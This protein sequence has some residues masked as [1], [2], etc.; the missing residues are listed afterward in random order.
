MNTNDVSGTIKF[1]VP[2]K[3]VTNVSNQF[4]RNSENGMLYYIK[5]VINKEPEKCLAT[6]LNG[7]TQVYTTMRICKLDV[8]IPYLAVG[9]DEYEILYQSY[10]ILLGSFNEYT[11][12][13]RVYIGHTMQIKKQAIIGDAITVVDHKLPNCSDSGKIADIFE[14]KHIE[15][16][17]KQYVIHFD[18]RAKPYIVYLKRAQFKLTERPDFNHRVSLTC[19]ICATQLKRKR[20]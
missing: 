18:N 9:V 2:K 11:E 4:A 14:F 19:P 3:P 13:N 12:G 8:V 5:H 1:K 10:P 20:K 17:L 6:I 16:K 7:K 15:S